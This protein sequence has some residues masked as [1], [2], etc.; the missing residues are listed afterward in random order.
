MLVACAEDGTIIGFRAFMRWM[1]WRG[2]RYIPAVRA[3]DTATHPDWQGKG[4]FKRLTLILIDQVRDNG[5]EFVFNTPNPQSRSGY[6]KMG[7]SVVGRV[8][9]WVRPLSAGSFLGDSSV[10]QTQPDIGRSMPELLE[11][12]W[13]QE[14]CEAPRCQRKKLSTAVSVEY[15][16]WRYHDVPGQNYRAVYKAESGEAA[17]IIFAFRRRPRR[18][19]E[20][21]ICDMFTAAGVRRSTLVSRLFADLLDISR[22]CGVTYIVASSG[23]SR[24]TAR[25]LLGR[26]FLPL[27][28]SGPILTV[29]ALSGRAPM[30]LS[31]W[32]SSIGTLE[33]F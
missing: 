8:N 27:P 15:L 10:N 3:V 7:W 26:R 9:L 30:N 14:V 6:L 17:A 25:L 29:R 28:R 21:R 11:Q 5:A 13:L 1:W 33:L 4:I 24:A 23:G 16:R 12:P 20:L 32:G 2:G 22:H 31:E 18:I 19:V